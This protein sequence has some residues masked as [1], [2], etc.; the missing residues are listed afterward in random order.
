VGFARDAW[1]PGKAHNHKYLYEL[2]V[3]S[4]EKQ[5]NLEGFFSGPERPAPEVTSALL[6]FETWVSGGDEKMP[7]SWHL[8]APDQPLQLAIID[9]AFSMSYVWK[10][11]TTQRAGL[12]AFAVSKR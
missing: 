12:T 10:F 1:A 4:E 2:T 9:Y 7:T 11:R 3:L 6:G 8:P 5:L